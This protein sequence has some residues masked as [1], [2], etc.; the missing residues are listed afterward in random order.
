M[1][2][3]GPCPTPAWAALISRQAPQPHR[4][5]RGF[6]RS[7]EHPGHGPAAGRIHGCGPASRKRPCF[8]HDRVSPS[9]HQTPLLRSP[10]TPRKAGPHPLRHPVAPERTQDSLSGHGSRGRHLATPGGPA[11][12]MGSRLQDSPPPPPAG[13]GTHPLLRSSP[14]LPHCDSC[15]PPAISVP[16]PLSSGQGTWESLR[17]LALTPACLL[18]GQLCSGLSA[19]GASQ[20][21]RRAGCQP[22]QGAALQPPGQ[23]TACLSLLGC[24]L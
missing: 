18:R 12:E 11:L 16:L 3:E 14:S 2:L 17:I 21:P 22:G 13:P 24:L 4:W 19:A 15:A 8:S 7:P 9:T 6:H 20:R 10:P 5:V 23:G 1:G